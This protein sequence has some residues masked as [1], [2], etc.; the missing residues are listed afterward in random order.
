[1]N[2]VQSL[3]QIQPDKTFKDFF[4]QRKTIGLTVLSVFEQL[5]IPAIMTT[6]L[7]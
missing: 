5:Q 3:N 6:A 4:N 7:L 2:F 1:M